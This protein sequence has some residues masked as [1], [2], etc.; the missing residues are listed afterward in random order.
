M[1]KLAHRGV[2]SPVLQQFQSTKYLLKFIKEEKSA[3]FWNTASGFHWT[4]LWKEVSFFLLWRMKIAFSIVFPSLDHHLSKSHDKSLRWEIIILFLPVDGH[5]SPWGQYS[6]CT[7]T[8]GRGS[9]YRNRAC[10]NPA[11]SS[12][13]KHCLGPSQQSNECNTQGCPG[14]HILTFWFI[15]FLN[16]LFELVWLRSISIIITDHAISI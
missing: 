9:Q 12:G 15:P 2:K 3:G 16:V 5:W 6:Q 7:K 1:L 10:D 11:P 14:K 13:G 4:Q 8:C